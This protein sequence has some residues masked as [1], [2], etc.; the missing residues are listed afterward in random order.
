MLLHA[1]KGHVMLATQGRDFRDAQD[2]EGYIV[3]AWG[4]VVAEAIRSQRW[5]W[6]CGG[7]DMTLIRQVSEP[8]ARA[9]RGFYADGDE[10]EGDLFTYTLVLLSEPQHW[11]AVKHVASALLNPAAR[12]VLSRR[13]LREILGAALPDVP[14]PRDD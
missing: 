1:N 3:H 13:R 5:P 12:G 8:L 9:S 4:G 7:W 10:L 6:Y 11:A 14:W 2:A